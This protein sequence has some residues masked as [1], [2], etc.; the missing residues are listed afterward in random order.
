MSSAVR[1]RARGELAI[2]VKHHNTFAE[3]LAIA[4]S[5]GRIKI[6]RS[7]LS[8]RRVI[9]MS[10]EHKGSGTKTETVQ[11]GLFGKCF[12][13]PRV[14]SWVAEQALLGLYEDLQM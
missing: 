4:C 11:M 10:R 3:N 8:L 6:D 12:P 2:I 5:T 13:N 1:H 14:T 7:Q 9:H